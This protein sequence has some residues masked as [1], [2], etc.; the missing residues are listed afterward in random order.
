VKTLNQANLVIK[1]KLLDKD[2]NQV[3]D[4][5]LNLVI[6]EKLLDKDRNQVVLNLVDNKDRNQANQVKLVIKE[7]RE[8]HLARELNLVDNKDHNQANLVTREP[9]E[10]HPLNLVDNLV[11]NKDRNLMVLN[12]AN[13]VIKEK[14]LDKDRNQLVLN[15]ANPVIKEPL[16]LP[17]KDRNQL[18]LNPELKLVEIHVKLELVQA[19]KQILEV[20]VWEPVLMLKP[21][22]NQRPFYKSNT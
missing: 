2:R 21:A 15:L 1:E 3:V 18:V 22:A 7:P 9:Q 20:L 6:K 11:D 16:K 8:A 13:R 10:A 5:V 17:D 4:K 14:L 12:Q 19:D